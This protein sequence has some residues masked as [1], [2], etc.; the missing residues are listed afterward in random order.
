VYH[1]YQFE[2]FIAVYSFV[3][4][5]FVA[6]YAFVCLH[7]GQA[8]NQL[9]EVVPHHWLHQYIHNYW[10]QFVNGAVSMVMQFRPETRL[11]QCK[12]LWD[13]KVIGLSHAHADR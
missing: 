2:K 5:N 9:N 3:C 1:Q 4:E 7:H 13:S 8:L 6:V 10:N 12:L 11:R